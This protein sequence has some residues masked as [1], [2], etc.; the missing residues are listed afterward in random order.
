MNEDEFESTP[1]SNKQ[2]E[3]ILV[4]QQVIL[5]AIAEDQR[6]AEILDKVCILAEGLLGNCAASIM[7]LHKNNRLM[8]AIS[9]P[10]IPEPK[11]VKLSNVRADI[12]YG[13]CT[14]AVFFDAP[15]Y[16]HNPLTDHRTAKVLDRVKDFNIG[17]CWSVPILDRNK[18]VLGSFSI[19]SFEQSIPTAYHDRLMKACA[20]IISILLERKAH[21]RQVMT[22]KLTGLWN[23]VQLDTQLLMKKQAY[24]RDF[25][26]YCLMVIDVDH[27]K[28]VNDNCGHNA[29][30][31][32]LVELANI[33]TRTVRTNDIVGRWGSDEF[34]VL[35]SNTDSDKA[36]IVAEKIRLAVQHNEFTDVSNVSVSLGVFEINQD[37]DTREAVVCSYK[38]LQEAKAK[39]RNQVSVWVSETKAEAETAF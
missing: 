20:T 9:S 13:S 27:F 7:L 21:E 24:L 38:A 14:A 2:L 17:S 33:L 8:S 12:G 4:I 3:S 35:V 32:V 18:K 34:M 28:T 25:E 30:D 5:R 10:S 31:A 39:G 36:R 19:S 26:T 15:A 6:D 1:I 23:R 16:I 22:D 11:R 29:G 37:M